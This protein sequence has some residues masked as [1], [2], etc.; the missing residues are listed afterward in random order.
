MGAKEDLN[1]V[2]TGYEAFGRGDIPAVLA[3]FDPS[4]AWHIPGRNS[5][6]GT[7]KG[8]DEVVG[9]FTQLG[10]RTGGTFNLEVHDM[11]AS[12]DHVVVLA[13]ESGRGGGKSLDVNGAHI[14]H[15]RDG[16]AVEFW[17]I[18]SDQHAMDDFWG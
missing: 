11:L 8:P 2:R 15:L 6:S 5:M 12:D 16:K 9:F 7:Y 4:I 1:T 17:G 10:E 14:W 13:R 18:P 3:I